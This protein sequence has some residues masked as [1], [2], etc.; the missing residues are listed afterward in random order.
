MK[1]LSFNRYPRDAF[2][3]VSET[4]PAA[5]D[6]VHGPAGPAYQALQSFMQV[7]GIGPAELAEAFATGGLDPMTES[8]IEQSGGIGALDRH[9]DGADL[10]RTLRRIA[11]EKWGML[12]RTV[13]SGWNITGTMDFGRIVFEMVEHK[14]LS[15]RPE[16]RID[17]FKD[18]FDF[19]D[20]DNYRIDDDGNCDISDLL[21]G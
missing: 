1:T 5:V 9:V 17:D 2:R 19:S 21:D 12:A 15:K 4:L 13:L 14:A 3:F 6:E 20:F 11:S 7:N 8:L 10:C 18:A 16:D